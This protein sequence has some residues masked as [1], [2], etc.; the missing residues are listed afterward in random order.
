MWGVIWS[1]PGVGC[2]VG[3]AVGLDVGAGVGSNVS[4]GTVGF[5]VG[6]ER[7]NGRNW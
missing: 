2:S 5:G 7:M 1:L 4:P 6:A 3:V